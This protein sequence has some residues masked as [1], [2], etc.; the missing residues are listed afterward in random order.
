MKKLTSKDNTGPLFLL[1]VEDGVG[2]SAGHVVVSTNGWPGTKLTLVV[3]TD[4][5]PRLGSIERLTVQGETEG[6]LWTYIL[7][8]HST[9]HH[10]LV[11]VAVVV[12][13]VL[14]VVKAVVVVAV[15]VITQVY[16]G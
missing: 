4:Q 2:H 7:S 9:R 6:R 16:D 1:S 3:T 14:V 5:C 12:V 13:A 8:E 15:V 11:N 10:G